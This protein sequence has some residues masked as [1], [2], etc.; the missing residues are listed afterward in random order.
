MYASCTNTLCIVPTAN[1]CKKESQSKVSK[2]KKKHYKIINLQLEKQISRCC[3]LK[4]VRCRVGIP[5]GFCMFSKS[6]KMK[7]HQF[8]SLLIVE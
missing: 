5:K 4:L 2:T 8:E 7:K 3:T 1:I 6:F